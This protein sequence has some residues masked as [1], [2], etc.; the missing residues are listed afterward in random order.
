MAFR[1]SMGH[2][3]SK[4]AFRRGGKVKARNYQMPNVHRGGIRL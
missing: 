1:K 4:R 2:G 3:A